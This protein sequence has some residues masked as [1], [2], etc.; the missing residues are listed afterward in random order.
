VREQRAEYAEYI[1]TYRGQ[2]VALLLPLGEEP[3]ENMQQQSLIRPKPTAALLAELE[4]LR[5]KIGHAWK[6]KLSAA[7]A[8]A[9]QRR[10]L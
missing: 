4:A 6:T 9:E 5:Q 1:V 7:E 10:A 8:V 3:R 2:P